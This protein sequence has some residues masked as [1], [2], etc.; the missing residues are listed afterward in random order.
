M[1][2]RWPYFLQQ[3]NIIIE[4]STKWEKPIQRQVFLKRKTTRNV[5]NTQTEFSRDATR[6][7][8]RT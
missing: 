1:Y 3:S 5:S 8:M 4:V 6:N 2:E 7:L